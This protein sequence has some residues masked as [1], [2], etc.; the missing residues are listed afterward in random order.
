MSVLRIKIH[1]ERD[2]NNHGAQII[3]DNTAKNVLKLLIN[4]DD[5]RFRF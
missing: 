3:N 5:K 2:A 4:L 1:Q